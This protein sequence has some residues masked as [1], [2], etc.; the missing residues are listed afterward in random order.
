MLELNGRAL[1]QINSQYLKKSQK[2]IKVNKMYTS[3]FLS[4]CSQCHTTISARQVISCPHE[5][6]SAS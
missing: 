1:P 4:V 5:V 6:L 2:F 3:L